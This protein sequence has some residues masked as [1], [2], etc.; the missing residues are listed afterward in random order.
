MEKTRKRKHIQIIVAVAC[1]L[2]VGATM[3]WLGYSTKKETSLTVAKVELSVTFDMQNSL[4]GVAGGDTVVNSIKFSPASGTIDCYV[5]ANLSYYKDGS[6]TDADKRY[7]LALNAENITTGTDSSTYKWVHHTDGFYY[8]TNMSGVP[9]I[10]KS[11][12]SQYT[13]CNAVTFTG[14]VSLYANVST[15]SNL[16]LGAE[17]Q[18][19]QAKNISANTLDTIAPY[20]NQTFGAPSK[21]GYIIKFDSN[22]GTAVPAQTFLKDGLTATTPTAPT[23]LG[24][25]F[26]GWYTDDDLTYAYSFSSVVNKNLTLYAKYTAA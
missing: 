17:I 19:V 5:R 20:F 15:P 8:L 24:Y 26:S 21:I 25:T 12:A 22:G 13:F 11:N 7:L 18:A 16:K 23:K 10:Y 2:V 6:M 1:I 14:P 3:A 9:V 4:T